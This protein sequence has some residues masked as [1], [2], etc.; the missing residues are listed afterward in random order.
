MPC[1]AG[2]TPRALRHAPGDRSPGARET[3]RDGEP[4]DISVHR[5]QAPGTRCIVCIDSTT[6]AQSVEPSAS[7]S[8]ASCKEW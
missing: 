4:R 1:A 8:G 6:C 3:E 5:E 2:R 7:S